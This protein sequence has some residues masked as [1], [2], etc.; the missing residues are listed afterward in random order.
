[1][2]PKTAMS[3]TYLRNAKHS[4]QTKQIRVRCAKTSSIHSVIKASTKTAVKGSKR[5][6]S[7]YS[8]RNLSRPLSVRTRT[9]SFSRSNLS[10]C[11]CRQPFTWV[12]VE[13]VLSHTLDRNYMAMRSIS[14]ENFCSF[15]NHKLKC[16]LW[17]RKSSMKRWWL[18]KRPET[19]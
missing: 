2:S 5:W 10:R 12:A 13:S 15:I 19:S 4:V 17:N 14:A 7:R 16:G 18:L 11:K 1:M 3:W 6:N 8:S 9:I